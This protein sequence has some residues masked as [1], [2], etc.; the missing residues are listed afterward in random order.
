[1]GQKVSVTF[2]C[3]LFFPSSLGLSW[4]SVLD[5]FLTHLLGYC[6][7]QACGWV[8]VCECPPLGGQQARS[9]LPTSACLLNPW[10][11]LMSLLPEMT[12]LYQKGSGQ[13]RQTGSLSPFCKIPLFFL[14]AYN[15]HLYVTTANKQITFLHS[16]RQDISLLFLTSKS[17]TKLS[18]QCILLSDSTLWINAM[19]WLP[20]YHLWKMFPMNFVKI[21]I[22]SWVYFL[23]FQL[24]VRFERSKLDVYLLKA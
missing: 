21:L 2:G 22:W 23:F 4:R 6:T 13:T 12:S 10:A 24:K 8:R 20:R 11:D 16:W 17:H 5:A 7:L 18:R 9:F 15:T 1:M 3:P 19:Q 14:M